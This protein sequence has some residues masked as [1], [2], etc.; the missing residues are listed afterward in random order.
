MTS[1]KGAAM[2]RDVPERPTVPPYVAHRTFQNFITQLR[3]SSVPGQIDRSVMEGLAGGTQSQLLSALKALG[4]VDANGIPTDVLHKLVEAEGVER[5]KTLADIIRHTYPS[6]FNA[7]F[8]LDRATTRQVV[9]KFSELGASGA[10]LGKCLAFFIAIS[11]E[12]NIPLSP[13]IRPMAT[14]STPRVRRVSVR[15]SG[16]PADAD[17]ENEEIENSEPGPAW[18]QMLLAKFPEFDPTWTDEVKA[19]WFEGFE[20][21][22]HAAGGKR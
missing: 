3:E 17:S 19:K 9:D 16:A 1:Q 7:G 18:A 11:K 6:L 15:D 20:R 5:Q 2:P 4:L 22:M 10:T 21:L 12:A 8:D 13:H 14:T